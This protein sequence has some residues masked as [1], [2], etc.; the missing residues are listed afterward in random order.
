MTEIL[1]TRVR[2]VAIALVVCL[3]A[4]TA[5]TAVG[6]AAAQTDAD[7]A[8][9]EP[10]DTFENATRLEP[11]NYTGLNVT[12]NDL[13]VYAVELSEGE[14]L[15]AGIDFSHA[16]GDLDLFLLGPNGSTL[17]A[18]VSET[19]GENV[20]AVAPEAGTYYL[21]VAGFRGASGPYDLRVSTTGTGPSPAAGEFEPND[22]FETATP[23]EAGNYTGLNV[24]END[25]DVYAVELAAGDALSAEIDFSHARGDLELLLVGPE[26]TILQVSTSVTDGET[27][28]HLAGTNGTYYLVVY[29]YLDG[30]GPYDLS[31]GVSSGEDG[32]PPAEPSPTETPNEETPT[33]DSP[34][35]TS[36]TAADET[37]SPSDPERDRLGWER[38]YW[39][40]ES[41]DVE[42][43]DGLS[44][45]ER[46][47]LVARSMAR[48]EA[49]R[50]REFERPVEFDVVSRAA[51][52]ANR[53]RDSFQ[54]IVGSRYYNQV[55]EATFIVDEETDAYDAVT[56]G[57]SAA[58]G[59]FYA[60]GSDRFVLVVEDP[61]DPN[62]D[63]GI[64]VHELTHAL[65][66]QTGLLDSAFRLPTPS[67]DART[68]LLGLVEGDANYVMA[69]YDARC[70]NG[71]WEC[72]P[73]DAS[74]SVGGDGDESAGEADG[75]DGVNLGVYL[76]GYQPYSDG[77][78]LVAALRERGG[79]DAVDA[80][81][82]SPPVST[83]QTIHPERYPDERPASLDRREP[84]DGEWQRF[85]TDTIGEAWLYSMFWYQDR[86]Y[87]I[88]V[89]DSEQ[90]LS[91]DAGDYDTY[92]YT[93][94]PSEGWANDRISLY[95][96]G[97]ASGYVWVT[98]WDSEDDAR[99]FA[100]A[101]RRVLEGHGGESV[102]DGTWR[103]P[104]EDPYGDAFRVVRDDQ[105]VTVVNGPD[106][107]A[108]SAIAPDVEQESSDEG[109]DGDNGDTDEPESATVP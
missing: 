11:G 39:A 102:G 21:V 65:Q 86:E 44:E 62:V 49:I 25:L 69:R 61:D 96:N 48:V 29:G 13:D 32:A 105:T 28:S 10:N 17:R 87:D 95:A 54:R 9:F 19:D 64:L 97:D 82:D 66:D 94:A 24:T 42:T 78:A 55:Y 1:S 73:R 79:W 98:A 107:D 84:T 59:G 15:S 35:Q 104:E 83:E 22:D 33:P 46:R 81:Y 90:V 63:E 2:T 47:A 50:E 58:V 3:A 57:Q 100:E 75:P 60:V 12:E 38:G 36:E 16:R 18:G 23:V 41:L 109:E 77:P 93:S 43:G 71:T 91:P 106:V 108:L 85:T 4:V 45:A 37:P 27:I 88:P 101:Y 52:A 26:R 20:S 40:N 67:S 56:G 30:T 70:A 6:T 80:A 53:S 99:Q 34:I 74:A 72:L 89:V 31:I 14:S 51:Y 103:I 5:T 68:G 7:E 76:T 92:N 8:A